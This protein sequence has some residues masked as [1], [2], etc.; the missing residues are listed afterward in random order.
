VDKTVTASLIIALLLVLLGLA[1][2]GWRNRQKRQ[3]ALAVP[4]AP[5]AEQGAVY[6]EFPGFYVATTM[7]GERFNRI[8]VHGLGFRAATTVS[9]TEA[10][11]VIPIAGQ[12]DTFIPAPSILAAAPASWTIDR[13]VEE[14]GLT[15]ITW[16]LGD[17]T[18]D[19]YFRL[20]DPIGA[21]AALARTA[22]ITTESES[23]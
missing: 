14:D 16:T 9:V 1:A 11:V 3:R 12:R 15:A 21:L 17:T 10:G 19:S 20:Q 8:A 23:K 22:P 18:V 5:P 13:G 7:S 6:G 4:A 2:L